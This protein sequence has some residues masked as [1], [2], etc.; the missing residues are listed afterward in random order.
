MISRVNEWA[1][2]ADAMSKWIWRLRFRSLGVDVKRM[3]YERIMVST[4]LY[5]TRE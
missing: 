5:G 1:K 3:R 2:V 4:W